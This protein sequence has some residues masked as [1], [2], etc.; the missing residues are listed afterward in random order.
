M[1]YAIV[2]HFDEE[3]ATYFNGIIKAIAESGSSSYMVDNKT[4]PHITIADFYTEN[5]DVIITAL[6][7]N[8]AIFSAGE[9]TWASLGSFIPRVLFAAPILIQCTPVKEIKTWSLV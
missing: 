2:L 4:I 3:T 6:D 8:S 9:V 1:E 5:I 7:N